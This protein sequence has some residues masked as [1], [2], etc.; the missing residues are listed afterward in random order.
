MGETLPKQAILIV[1]AMSRVGAEGFSQARELLE[2]AGI[3]LIDAIAV[4]QPARLKSAV[5]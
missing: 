2:S 4:K 1:N 3:E 5:R